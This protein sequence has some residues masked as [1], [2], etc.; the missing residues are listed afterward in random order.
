M[1]AVNREVL[2][3]SLPEIRYVRW[4]R[5]VDKADVV[6]CGRGREDL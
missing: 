5:E 4:C 3:S 1:E 2:A 6:S